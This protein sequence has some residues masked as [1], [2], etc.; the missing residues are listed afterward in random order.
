MHYNYYKR[1]YIENTFA[2][3]LAVGSLRSHLAGQGAGELNI[4]DATSDHVEIEIATYS[5][6][7]MDYAEDRLAAYV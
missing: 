3:G 1:I 2:A 5:P 4:I 6:L 7:V